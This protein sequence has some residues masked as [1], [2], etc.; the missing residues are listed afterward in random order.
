MATIR[1]IS[2]IITLA[3]AA[4]TPYALSA[5]PVKP[6]GYD[7]KHAPQRPEEPAAVPQGSA[8]LDAKIA[9]LR[10][11]RERL[12]RASTLEEKQALVAER[13][14][15]IR[16]AMA[17][18]HQVSGMP[19]PA[20]TRPPGAGGKTPAARAGMCYDPAGQHVALMQEMMLAMGDG[21]G[22][23]A[24]V[25]PGPGQGMHRGMMPR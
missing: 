10:A 25:G 11:I 3:V 23:G 24:G 5:P 4:W 8:D 18:V 13:T 21:Q 9:H 2:L 14:V 20:G 15:V 12:S 1:S 6:A 7:G 22:M 17:T 16:D 19:A